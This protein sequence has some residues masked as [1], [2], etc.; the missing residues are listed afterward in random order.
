MEERERRE[1]NRDSPNTIP[2]KGIVAFSVFFSL[3]SFTIL[4]LTSFRTNGERE[5]KK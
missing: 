3:L 4:K 5:E 1:K 2:T